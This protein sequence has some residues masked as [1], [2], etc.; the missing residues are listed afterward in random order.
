MLL[1]QNY[2]DYLLLEKRY[3]THTVKAYKTDLSL[4]QDYLKEIFYKDIEDIQNLLDMWKKITYSDNDSIKQGG[5][6]I[7]I[8]KS[9]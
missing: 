1:I 8:P 9:S 3:S 6:S 2:L 4:F 7:M 5:A